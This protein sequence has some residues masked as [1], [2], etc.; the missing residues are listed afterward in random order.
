MIAIPPALISAACAAEPCTDVAGSTPDG[1]ET[2]KPADA[3]A[4]LLAQRLTALGRWRKSSAIAFRIRGGLNA[5]SGAM[6]A[7]SPAADVSR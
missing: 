4:V 6:I 3:L 7:N 2:G 5:P 1:V